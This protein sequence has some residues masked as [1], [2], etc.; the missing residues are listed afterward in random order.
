MEK[1]E[2]KLDKF[3]EEA[4][5]LAEK[6]Y[7]VIVSAPTGA[8]K[9]LI[10]E[11]IIRRCIHLH[12]KV[13][14]TAPIKA[15][16]NQKFRDFSKTWPKTTGIL[17]GDVSINPGAPLLIMTTEI[18]RNS[19]LVDP[20]NLE[21]C[22]WVIFDEIHYLDD[23]ERGT[24]WEESIILLP[25]HIRML[26]LSATIPNIDEFV[27]WLKKI[28]PFPVKTVVEKKRPVP[29]HFFFQCNNEIFSS[30]KKLE[31]SHY[32]RKRAKQKTFKEGLHFFKANK[33][34]TL[35]NYLKGKGA[36]PCI[37]FAFSRRRCED[38][39][40]EVYSYDF[41]TK[42]EKKKIESIFLD[43]VEKFNISSDRSLTYLFPLIKKGIAYHH[44]GLLPTLKE[45][46]ER[47]FTTGLI[48]FIF[49]TETFALGINMPAKTV[50]FDNLIK[51]Y[52]RYTRYLKTRDFYQMAG[53]AGRRGI[54][55]EGYVFTRINPHQIDLTSLREIIYGR[56]EPIVSQLRSCYATILNLFLLMKEK[57][58]SIYPL[59][60]H[61]YQSQ[62]L[63]KKEAQNLLK[64]KLQLLKEV[65]YIIGN[66]LSWKGELAS[67]VYSFELQ[68][69]ELFESGFLESLDEKTLFMV[70]SSLVYEPRKGE[71]KPKLNKR[72]KRLKREL[73]LFIKEIHSQE[74][75]YRIY[76]LSKKFYFHLSE[77]SLAW[78]EGTDFYKLTRFSQVDEGELVRYFRMSIQVLREILSSKA[79]DASFK[80]K[81]KNCIRKVN[82]DVVDAEKQLR[83][84]I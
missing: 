44:A 22:R 51:F 39:A 14:Y 81:I 18:F 7:S 73:N 60:F 55:K 48:K 79:I 27:N 35:I 21:E 63:E 6:G 78:Y 37:Y 57:L 28:H 32:L 3:Q 12:Q 36:L 83:Q 69:G 26:A 59:S 8:G 5:E 65:G 58:L 13:I 11:N 70:I 45:I 41:L 46:I 74:R 80:S 23:I 72:V 19:I 24:V 42:E 1:R 54:D 33:L 66:T 2:V 31:E 53:R 30:F 76:P 77:V 64:R 43:L 67:K 82:R 10:A 9:T 50:V 40:S 75:R 62:E 49:T 4:I 34:S 16:S 29:L 61:F 84:E 56:Y 20:T 68:I 15:L 71:R 47:L 38:L 52:G 17:T 25:K